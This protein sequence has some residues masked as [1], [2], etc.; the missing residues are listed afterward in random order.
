MEHPMSYGSDYHFIPVTYIES[1]ISHEILPN[2]LGL[3]V[4]IVNVFFVGVP[5]DGNW[6]LVD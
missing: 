6:V 5:G 4:Q 1:G 3:T 2:L